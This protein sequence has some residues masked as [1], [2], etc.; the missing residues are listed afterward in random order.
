M[1]TTVSHCDFVP[2]LAREVLALYADALPDVRF[3][4][5]DLQVLEGAAERV[6]DA[7]LEVAQALAELERMRGKLDERQAELNALAERALA[8][9]RVF[10]A[11]NPELSERVGALANATPS[12]TTPEPRRVSRKRRNKAQGDANLFGADESE[13]ARA[14]E[15]AA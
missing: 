1:P 4:D 11:G 2:T 10:A 8:Y 6:R 5:L 7:Q 9:A 15:S 14:T 13:G 12:E 3:P